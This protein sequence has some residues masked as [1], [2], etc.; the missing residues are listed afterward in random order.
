MR[1]RDKARAPFRTK[2]VSLGRVRTGID[3][4]AEVLA[5]AESETFR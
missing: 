1:S 5:S 3:N 4:V 2:A